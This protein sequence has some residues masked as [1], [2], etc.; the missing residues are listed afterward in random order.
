MYNKNQKVTEFGVLKPGDEFKVYRSYAWHTLKKINK[1]IINGETCNAIIIDRLNKGDIVT[2][3]FKDFE[4]VV[5]L[6]V[7]VNGNVD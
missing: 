4:D 6:P 5:F 7:G 1:T 2:D 3:Y